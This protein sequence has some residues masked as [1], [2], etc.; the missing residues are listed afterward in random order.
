MAGR[1]PPSLPAPRR[2]H[3]SSGSLRRD[4]MKKVRFLTPGA[5]MDIISQNKLDERVMATPAI[6]QGQ[7]ILRTEKALYAFAAASSPR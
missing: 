3:R 4:K 1:N 6:S 2:H 7:L 5:K